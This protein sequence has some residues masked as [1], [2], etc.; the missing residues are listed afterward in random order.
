MPMNEV[1]RRHLKEI[2][3]KSELVVYFVYHP[4]ASYAGYFTKLEIY[5]KPFD[6][7]QTP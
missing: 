6:K 7:T 5:Y 3:E 4:T 2:I 1:G